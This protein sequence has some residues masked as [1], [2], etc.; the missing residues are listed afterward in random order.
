MPEN[1]P[2]IL[3][4]MTDQQRY[5]TVAAY[6]LNPIC[7]TPNIDRLAANGVLFNHAFTPTAICSP[8]RASFYTGLYPHKHGVTA[9]SLTINEGV[10]GINNYLDDAGYVSGYSGK[11]HVD[12]ERGP[13]DLGFLG[14]DFLGYGF[15]GSKV[16]PGLQFGAGPLN[17][18]NHY[19]VY[20]RE[21]GFD[22]PTVKK[23]FSGQNP[24]T[25]RQEMF[26]LHDGPVESCIEYFVAQET[27][28]VMEDMAAGDKPFF[29]W[30]NFWGPHTPCVIPEPYFSMYDPRSIPEHPSYCET[31]DR[32]PG[33]Q[34]L[35]EKMWGLGDYGWAG[36]Q[37]IAARYYGHCTLIDDMVGR[38][39]DALERTGQAENT[40]VIFT[41]DHGDCLGA[42]KLIEKGEFM[43]DEIYRIPMVVSHPDCKNKGTVNE[44][45]YYLHELMCSSLDMAGLEVPEHLDGNSFLPAMLGDDSYNGREDVYCIFNRHF[46]QANQRMVR[47]K[48]HQLTFN[49]CDMGELYDLEND[50]YQLRNVHGEAAYKDIQRSLMDRMEVHMQSLDD[51]VKGWFNT[52]KAVY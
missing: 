26:A 3:V 29:M 19:E 31:F 43:Y 2:N 18:P 4:L 44:N 13:S 49:S 52:M 45:F 23:R 21:N 48:S 12:H 5:D 6:G 20:L 32:K 15:P 1:R 17:T 34:Q 39:L 40:V 10:R 33:V 25:S 7:Q 8:A 35:I 50:P 9:N 36:F 24:P 28:R 42:H 16:L 41:S 37:E 46:T 47:T 51:P 27:I 14:K 30:A 38:I 22:I 11:W